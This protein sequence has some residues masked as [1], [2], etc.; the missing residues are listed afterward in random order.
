MTVTVTKIHSV[1]QIGAATPSSDRTRRVHLL[2][3]GISD[4]TTDLTDSIVIDISTYLGPLGETPARLAL[5]RLGWSMSG[6]TSVNLEFDRGT[7]VMVAQMIG[8]DYKDFP[9]WLVDTATGGT[10]DL[11][12]NTVGATAG[13]VF[14]IEIEARLKF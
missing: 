7:D 9:N 1:P 5:R 4:S 2:V 12:L 14:S 11:V 10:G 8:N 6:F 13:A 3:N